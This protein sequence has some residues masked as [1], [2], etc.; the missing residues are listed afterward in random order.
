MTPEIL[1]SIA[2]VILSLLFSYVP[3][4]STW[5]EPLPGDLKRLVMLALLLL[6][7]LASF[8]LACAQISLENATVACSTPGALGLLKTFIAAMIANQSAYALSPR[9]TA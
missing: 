4:L 6:T 2:A 3:G 1:A 7:A 8:A 5:Y 9:K